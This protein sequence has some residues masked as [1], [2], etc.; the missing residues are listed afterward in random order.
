MHREC[1]QSPQSFVYTSPSTI[2]H[3]TNKEERKKEKSTI[4][5]CVQ[6]SWRLFQIHSKFKTDDSLL[7]NARICL[8]IVKSYFIQVFVIPFQLCR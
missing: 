3:K 5:Q 2:L 7:T 1:I 8:A 6:C 4:Q